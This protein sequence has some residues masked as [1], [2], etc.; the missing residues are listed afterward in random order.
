MSI[1]YY[2]ESLCLFKQKNHV[3]ELYA[4]DATS[5]FWKEM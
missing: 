2:P 4:T 1:F 5:C 3:P